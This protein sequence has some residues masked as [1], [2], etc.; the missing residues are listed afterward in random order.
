MPLSLFLRIFL[1]I[2]VIARDC[3]PVFCR[4]SIGANGLA[5]SDEALFKMAA[6]LALMFLVIFFIFFL[7]ISHPDFKE[8]IESTCSGRTYN[9]PNEVSAEYRPAD[10][11]F[12]VRKFS[13][14]S[15]LEELGTY[16]L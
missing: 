12:L 7:S 16:S 2:S 4:L 3:E 5:L 14:A 13:L 10:C 11:L 8:L 1:S 15:I 6:W 9:S